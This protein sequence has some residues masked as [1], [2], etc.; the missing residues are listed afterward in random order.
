MRAVWAWA[1]VGVLALVAACGCQDS[2][3]EAAAGSR[4]DRTSSV[5]NSQDVMFAEH[6]IPHHQQAL[7][8][9][10]MVPSRTGNEKLKTAAIHIKTDQRAE[11]SLLTDFL[12]QWGEPDPVPMPM[13]MME[14]MVDPATMGRLQTLTGDD[15]DTLWITS[16]ISHHQ[17]AI[18]MA[19]AE[20]AHGESPDA[21]KTAQLMITAQKREISY[22]TD[23]IAVPM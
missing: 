17:G 1:V 8:M 20:L 3:N 5:H 19:E 16:M 18:T 2:R 13:M 22:L 15:F 7:D 12:H 6:M 21:M 10:D 11:I 9:A 4:D 14:G 23:L